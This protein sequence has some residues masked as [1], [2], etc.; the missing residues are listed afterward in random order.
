MNGYDQSIADLLRT[1]I[2]DAQDLVRG[3]IALAKAELRQEARRAGAG[4]TML[5]AAAAAAVIALVFLLTAV[6]WGI[7]AALA[8]PVWTGFA[9]VGGVVLVT[10]AALGAIGK[11]RL[12]GHRHM[13]LTMD[14]MKENMQWTRAR[15]P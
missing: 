12:N 9:I 8:W 6:A 14:T 15:K 10:A 7:Q 11:N 2:Q 4:L 1:T 13:P 3:E 5:A